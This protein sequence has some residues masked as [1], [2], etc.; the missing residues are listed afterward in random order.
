[1]AGKWEAHLG[2]LGEL[3]AARGRQLHPIR[4]VLVRWTPENVA[5]FV[6]HVGFG[7]PR[8]ERAQHVELCDDAA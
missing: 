2:T 6:D 3:N 4:P 5:A 1:M 7:V 8:E